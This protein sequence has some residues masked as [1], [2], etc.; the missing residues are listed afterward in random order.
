M[1]CAPTEAD[2]IIHYDLT[3]VIYSFEVVAPIAQA[4]HEQGKTI[5][6]HLEVDSGLGRLGVRP[7]E[8]A[9]LARIVLAAGNLRPVGVMTHFASADDPSKD[10]FTSDQVQGFKRAIDSLR[11]IGLTNLIC[12]ASATAATPRIPDARFD[13]VRL[14]LGMYGICP[15]AEVGRKID[16]ELA[17][18]LVSRVVK[19]NIYQKGDHIG[20]GGTFKVPYD[21]FR[22]GVVPLGYH[23]GIPRILSNR[24]SVL[25]NGRTARIIGNISMDSMTIDL[26]AVPDADLQ[27]D[28]LV[29][30]KY[31]GYVVRP[32]AVAE[33]AET[34]AYELLARLGPR[35]QRVFTGWLN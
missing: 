18:S 28:V 27:T 31:A 11:G 7:G 21:G 17:I 25:V 8:V 12:H 23:D 33:T 4:A 15:S 6:V 22:A 13:M 20:Y 32:E 35:V 29:Y 2:K 9:E 19:I 10:A 34:I 14:G 5:D 24:G 3:P 26:S 1:M 16:L 30:G